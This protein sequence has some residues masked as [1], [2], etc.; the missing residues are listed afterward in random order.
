MLLI[1][2]YSFTYIITSGLFEYLLNLNNVNTTF[3]Y[4][5]QKC[6]LIV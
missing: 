6:I 3:K 4:H 2:A 1:R 5:W